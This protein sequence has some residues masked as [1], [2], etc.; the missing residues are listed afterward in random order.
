MNF[1]KI[2]MQI[3]YVFTDSRGRLS[4]HHRP[5][6][7][8]SHL[9]RMAKDL[10]AVCGANYAVFV[11]VGAIDN[12]S[13]AAVYS[14]DFAGAYGMLPYG[15]ATATSACHPRAKRRISRRYYATHR[16]FNHIQKFIKKF[17]CYIVEKIYLLCYTFFVLYFCL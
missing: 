8:R 13:L 16:I 15:V 1:Y 14:A 3:C 9:E 6:P 17:C 4:L 7:L 5:R 2:I 12:P 10:A 11:G